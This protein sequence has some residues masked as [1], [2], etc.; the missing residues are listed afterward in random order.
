[1][2]DAD[3][4]TDKP[5]ANRWRLMMW[6]TA[7]LL[8]LLP[9]VAMEF[10]TE[11][12][13]TGSDF[14]VFGAMLL[15]M[16]G[17]CELAARASRSRAYRTAVMIAVVTALML[18]WLNLAVG[19]L[20]NEGNPANLMFAGVLGVALVGTVAARMRPRSMSWVLLATAL[21]QALVAALAL[22]RGF[23][24]DALLAAIFVAPWLASAGL[25]RVAAARS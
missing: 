5:S 3:E 15:A 12:A 20:G 21:A 2:T 17:A 7:V 10:T 24:F 9:W 18:V 14:L 8:L 13:W 1:M 11:V 6:A 23:G 16:C 4:V 25:F 22:A 19:I